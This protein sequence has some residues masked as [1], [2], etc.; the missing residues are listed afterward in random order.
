L[1]GTPQTTASD[2]DSPTLRALRRMVADY[3]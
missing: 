1:E 3:A 2:A